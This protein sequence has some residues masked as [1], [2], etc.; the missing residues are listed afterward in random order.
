MKKKLPLFVYCAACRTCRHRKF[1]SLF[2]DKAMLDCADCNG[3][4]VQTVIP[5]VLWRISWCKLYSKK[6]KYKF[7]YYCTQ[8]NI[9]KTNGCQYSSSGYE[10]LMP[11]KGCNY[12]DDKNNRFK[13]DV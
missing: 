6:R 13:G 5:F 3:L 4:T 1:K 11:Y 2:D 10:C 12:Q 9:A 8:P 7:P